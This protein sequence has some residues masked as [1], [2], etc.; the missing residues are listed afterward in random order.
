[1]PAVTADTLT[2]PRVEIPD[3]LLRTDRPV[4][5]VTTAPSGFEG[6]GFPVKRAFA[7]VDLRAARPV[8]PHGPDGRGRVRTG[9][10]QGHRRGT[11]TA[12]SRP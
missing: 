5:S 2:L 8:R 11:R 3:A 12:A 6:E 1:M 9:R 4:V 7:G 10:A